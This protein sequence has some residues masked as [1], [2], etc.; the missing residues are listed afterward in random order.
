MCVT[1]DVNNHDMMVVGRAAITVRTI[2]AESGPDEKLDHVD[3]NQD[4]ASVA[5]R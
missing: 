4:I 1:S 2:D 5:N 3:L